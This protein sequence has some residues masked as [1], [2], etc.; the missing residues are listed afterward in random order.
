M[1]KVGQKKLLLSNFAVV[2]DLYWRLYLRSFLSKSTCINLLPLI[3]YVFAFI[4][5]IERF[6]AF[7]GVFVR[8]CVAIYRLQC[9][10][11]YYHVFRSIPMILWTLYEYPR[12]CVDVGVARHSVCV[13]R[14]FSKRII[15]CLG[16]SKV[17]NTN[18]FFLL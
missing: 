3:Q 9:F 11:I 18:T 1:R 5:C 2:H 8:T 4:F 14:V 15:K 7:I 17:S 10:C 13:F 6:Y 12:V 16:C